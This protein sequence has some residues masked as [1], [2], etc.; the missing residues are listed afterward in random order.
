MKPEKPEAH[1]ILFTGLDD[2]GKTC[3]TS[4]LKREFSQISRIEPTKHA[5]REVFKLLGKEIVTWDLGGQ[6]VYRMEY[7]ESPSKIFRGTGVVIYVIDIQNVPRIPESLKYL[8]EV[9]ATLK[10][11]NIE[12]SINIFFHKYDPFDS[13]SSQNEADSL[14]DDVKKKIGNLVDHEKMFFFNTSIFNLYSIMS[15]MSEILKDLSPKMEMI[16][17]TVDDF[18]KVIKCDGLMIIDDNSIIISHYANSD[19]TLLLIERIVEYFLLLNDRFLKRQ[20]KDQIM[21]YKLGKHV[22][23][24]QLALNEKIHYVLIVLGQD[25]DPFHLWNVEKDFIAFISDLNEIINY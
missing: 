18:V 4:A 13:V 12:P 17:E 7:L 5:K 19:E 8:N 11:L 6:E 10:E 23:F 22:L 16:Q 3:I 24:K 25:T 20:E 14:T 9:I 1:K 2:A 15:A 21:A